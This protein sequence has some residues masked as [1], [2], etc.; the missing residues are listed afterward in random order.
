MPFFLK[1]LELPENVFIILRDLIRDRTGL[2][3]DN[4]KRDMLADK[5]SPRV[6]E[7]GFNSFLDYYYLLKY[8][9]TAAAEW[10][11]LINALSVPETFFWRE[12]DQIQS[13]VNLLL[14]QYLERNLC[15]SHSYR[16]KSGNIS[17]DVSQ[18]IRIWSAACSSGEE[19]LTI[20]MALQEAGWFQRCK[21]EI[22]ASDASEAAIAKAKTGIY[23]DRSF[24]NLSSYLKGKYFTKEP[25]GWRV[26]SEIHQRIN[27][28]IVNLLSPT[29]IKPL[30]WA[31]FIFC[32]NVFIYFSQDAIRQTALQF[33]NGM[34]TPGY[35]FLSS[36]ES[37]L[38]LDTG[39]DL[40]EIGNAFVYVKS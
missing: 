24:R 1:S 12:I 32:R 18:P 25:E 10:K 29:E 34:P 6:I 11:H 15:P 22:Y 14:P 16:E 19:P 33:F 7:L 13:L 35:L 23:R 3:Y 36:S 5:L 39:F 4:S 17:S 37:L 8:D 31:N 40:Q 30:T 2:Y 20:A 38:K 21:I 9:A 27:Y 26:S 28:S